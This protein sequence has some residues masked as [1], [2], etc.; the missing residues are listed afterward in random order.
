[1]GNRCATIV[2]L[3]PRLLIQ[4]VPECLDMFSRWY[5][6]KPNTGETRGQQRRNKRGKTKRLKDKEAKGGNAMTPEGCGRVIYQLL[7][8]T[9]DT[10]THCVM[11]EHISPRACGITSYQRLPPVTESFPQHCNKIL[12]LCA[13]PS[14]M[15]VFLNVKFH[16]WCT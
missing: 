2:Q 1:M 16:Y 11:K 3:T 13:I 6:R 15:R 12:S 7:K 14:L 5:L 8:A 10:F 9:A 4:R